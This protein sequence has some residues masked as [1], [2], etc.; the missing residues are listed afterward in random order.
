MLVLAIAAPAQA[1]SCTSSLD[2]S[3]AFGHTKTL[4]AAPA[5]AAP[6]A[7]AA[8]IP[9]ITGTV[10]IQELAKGVLGAVGAQGYGLVMQQLGLGAPDYTS[11]LEKL[12]RELT[13]LQTR[14]NQLSA[15]VAELQGI[16]SQAAY[17]NLVAQA[18]PI[19][20][21][22]RYVVDEIRLLPT[23]N[24][25]GQLREARSIL[26]YICSHLLDKQ[27]ELNDRIV[28]TAPTADSIIT[29]SSRA[30]RDSVRY[31][32]QHQSTT[33]RRVLE[34]YIEY[35]ALLLQ[36]R[37]EWW[38]AIGSSKDYKLAQISRV[39]QDVR[40]QHG[41]LKPDIERPHAA[42][43]R[44]Q[45]YFVDTKNPSLV[46]WPVR[47]YDVLPVYHADHFAELEKRKAAK[48]VT[49]DQFGL[50]AFSFKD[51]PHYGFLN[52]YA[53]GVRFLVRRQGFTRPEGLYGVGRNP[54]EQYLQFRDADLQKNDRFEWR[55]PSFS[56]MNALLNG[57]T[58]S[59]GEYLRSNA[60]PRMTAIVG[61]YDWNSNSAGTSPVVWTRADGPCCA[62]RLWDLNNGN[63]SGSVNTSGPNL[64]AGLIAV[65][66]ARSGGY[67]Y[68]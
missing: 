30:A 19:I 33:V 41:L 56:E 61:W 24:R 68:D 23:E 62:Y 13:A 47:V 43:E 18:T 35:E 53:G 11:K 31:W 1:S 45:H 8:F 37:V 55:L 5:A 46:W 54:G 51:F 36:L 32:T 29:A 39:E 66:A 2:A 48:N 10:V 28:G 4:R 59:P 49:W 6:R 9:G 34:Y 3:T 7:R 26:L 27:I 12:E 64:Y 22:I 14:L 15:S 38:N 25:Y 65:R 52:N 58:G 16:T 57:W 50:N 17:S 40:T 67:W 21:S 42:W 63:T 44:S 20:S 60:K